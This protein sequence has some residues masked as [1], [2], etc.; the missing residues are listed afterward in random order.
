MIFQAAQHLDLDLT[1][2]WLIGDS[3]RDIE[4]GRAAGCRT[5]LFR[6]PN[7]AASPAADEAAEVEPD[8]VSAS[9]TEAMDYIE[10]VSEPVHQKV[11]AQPAQRTGSQASTVRV[12]RALPEPEAATSRLERIAEQI[13]QELRRRRDEPSGDFSVPRLLAGI[14]QVITLAVLFMCYMYRG[15]GGVLVP[16]LLFALVLQ[17]FTI[18][19]LIMGRLK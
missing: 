4:A 8:H 12:D 11:R 16:L 6:D 10:S 19:L 1:R 5:I 17:T 14:A 18:A 3:P 2:S 15:N 9:L 7:L 13:L